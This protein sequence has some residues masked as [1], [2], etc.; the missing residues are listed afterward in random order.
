M[1]V[2]CAAGRSDEADDAKSD[3][4]IY[5]LRNRIASKWQKELQDAGCAVGTEP[6]AVH[7]GRNTRGRYDTVV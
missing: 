6:L 3:G 7:L 5:A 1:T 4:V 2:G